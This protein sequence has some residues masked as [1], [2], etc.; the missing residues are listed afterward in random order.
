MAP[1]QL[2]SENRFWTLSIILVS[3]A[4]RRRTWERMEFSERRS[5]LGFEGIK[6]LKHGFDGWLE[7]RFDTRNCQYFVEH[8]LEVAQ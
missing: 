6:L 8:W 7:N 1:V 5:R 3:N 4:P 2:S